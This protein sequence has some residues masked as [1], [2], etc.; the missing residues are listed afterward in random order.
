MP[1]E[2]HGPALTRYALVLRCGFAQLSLRNVV[3]GDVFLCTGQ[4]N[5]RM[6][7]IDEVVATGAGHL[8]PHP[9]L[10]M[11]L[12]RD[13]HDDLTL[14]LPDAQTITKKRHR[15]HTAHPYEAEGWTPADTAMAFADYSTL[16]Y[17]AGRA[18]ATAHTR[19]GSTIPIGLILAALV[20]REIR[21]FLPASTTRAAVCPGLSRDTPNWAW[22]C[23]Y[24]PM[25][26]LALSGVWW[27]QG[28]SDCSR[29]RGYSC[30]LKALLASW[31]KYLRSPSGTLFTV[32]VQLHAFP[33]KPSRVVAI[34]QAQQEVSQAMDNVALAT[35]YDTTTPSVHPLNKTMTALRVAHATLE[36][37]YRKQ[38]IV[39]PGPRLEFAAAPVVESGRRQRIVLQFHKGGP[40]TRY[41]GT[42]GYPSRECDVTDGFEVSLSLHSVTPLA[43]H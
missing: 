25:G 36:H 43:D 11:L 35:A 8:Q 4:S 22:N 19:N 29:P 17:T 5:M 42:T 40:A 9:H 30:R 26:G 28:E 21:Y 18:L 23:F 16:C 31:R 14:P 12:L 38:P 10:R 37:Y 32:I 2:P 33:D 13:V 34:R 41:W 27:Y 39:L 24:A 6:P 7:T 3:F 15:P 20:G 1:P